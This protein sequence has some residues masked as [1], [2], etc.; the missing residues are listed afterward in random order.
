MWRDTIGPQYRPS[1]CNQ[2]EVDA[3]TKSTD[4]GKSQ[5]AVTSRCQY[6]MSSSKVAITQNNIVEPFINGEPQSTAAQNV[7]VP[8]NTT[9]T[10]SLSTFTSSGIH[11]NTENPMIMRYTA[12]RIVF[13]AINLGRQPIPSE[14]NY[15]PSFTRQCQN[16]FLGSNVV[17][18]QVLV[19]PLNAT[20]NIV[21]H[22]EGKEL[23]SLSDQDTKG[24][25]NEQYQSSAKNPRQQKLAE[26]DVLNDNQFEDQY[27]E[28]KEENSR[29]SLLDCSS[30][31]RKFHL[32]S[33]QRK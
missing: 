6:G 5:K 16:I 4:S 26:T 21:R 13:S 15:L 25:Q 30:S 17:D 29:G 12:E 3:R 18:R 33:S 14:V 1:R 27:S 31:T 7:F 8:S 9:F 23:V 28:T 11:C 32:K 2:F 24:L 10:H 19:T 20:S 22:D